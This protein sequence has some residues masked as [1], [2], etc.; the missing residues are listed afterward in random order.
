[1]TA[2]PPGMR[3]CGT[4]WHW[5]PAE[6]RWLERRKSSAGYDVCPQCASNIKPPTPPVIAPD[7]PLTRPVRIK[8]RPMP[9]FAPR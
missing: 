2:R 6:G 5:A 4:G 9:K 8:Y 3:Y 1:M 7:A